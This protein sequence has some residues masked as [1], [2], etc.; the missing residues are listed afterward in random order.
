MKETLEGYIEWVEL[1]T[2]FPGY[3]VIYAF[4][5]LLAGTKQGNELI[6]KKIMPLLPV[7]YALV[8]VLY[9]GLMLKNAYP[10][11]EISAGMGPLSHPFLK[12]WGLLA[13]FGWIPFLFKRP[14]FSLIHSFVFF[15]L[16]LINLLKT[17]VDKITG[18]NSRQND[19]R[20][21]GASIGINLV[22]L[23]IVTGISILIYRLRKSPK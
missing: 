16:L 8:A 6:G 21:L 17:P 1:M 11:F 12:M 20:I 19:L 7:S 14:V 3:L 22:A 10:E 9:W 23:F 5:F 2:F 4:F 18:E 13:I 15:V